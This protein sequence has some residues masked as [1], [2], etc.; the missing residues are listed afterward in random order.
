[1]VLTRGS[2]VPIQSVA[3][4]FTRLEKPALLRR[5]QQPCVTLRARGISREHLD[6][7]VAELPAGATVEVGRSR[8]R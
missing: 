1:V 6:A 7:A 2:L 5:N 8:R 4:V 3:S